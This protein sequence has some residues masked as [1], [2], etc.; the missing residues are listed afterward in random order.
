MD[1]Y[2]TVKPLATCHLPSHQY[3]WRNRALPP[4]E[5]H[6]TAVRKNRTSG[7]PLEYIWYPLSDI[8]VNIRKQSL[9]FL[10]RLRLFKIAL[11][12]HHMSVLL[13]N[14]CV[15][16]NRSLLFY[17]NFCLNPIFRSLVI[18]CIK[19]TVACV[20]SWTDQSQNSDQCWQ[21]PGTIYFRPAQLCEG[22]G[23]RMD[24]LVSGQGLAT[25]E[26]PLALAE[27]SPLLT[28]EIDTSNGVAEVAQQ[29]ETELW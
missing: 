25:G 9:P 5:P 17:L 15:A 11:C 28:N 6:V 13:V 2:H 22:E 10:E 19:E 21:K 27:H 29:Q 1:T 23:G 8:A 3:V 20:A 24:S 16:I 14:V 18:C 7:V 4:I 26:G 12:G